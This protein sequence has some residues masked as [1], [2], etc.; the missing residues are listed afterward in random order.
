M[1]YNNIIVNKKEGNEIFYIYNDNGD[2]MRKPYNDL[3]DALL[4]LKEEKNAGF[5]ENDCF[6]VDEEGEEYD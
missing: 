2:L 3:Q 6:V 1:C 4:A 5:L